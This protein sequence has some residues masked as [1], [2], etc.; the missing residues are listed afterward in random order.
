MSDRT[1]SGREYFEWVELHQSFCS[2]R[3]GDGVESSAAIGL[4]MAYARCA[5]RRKVP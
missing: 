2:N 1:T 5:G 4:C 3:F